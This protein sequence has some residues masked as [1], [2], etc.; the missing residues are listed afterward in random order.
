MNIISMLEN[1]IKKLK[2]IRPKKRTH[3]T[4]GYINGEVEILK[5][6]LKD[7]Q[8]LVKTIENCFDESLKNNPYPLDIFVG[9]T[10]EGKIGIHNHNVW[11]SA[12]QDFMELI[13]IKIEEE[14]E[15]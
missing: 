8:E 3:Y 13:E 15:K 11:N 5:E 2:L 7:R 10:Q 4:D 14:L 1:R 9:N 6:W 12:I